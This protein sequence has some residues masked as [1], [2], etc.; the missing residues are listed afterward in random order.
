MRARGRR[1]RP[2]SLVDCD[3]CGRDFVVPV[4]WLDLDEERWWIRTRCGEC[5]TAREVVVGNE[6]ARRFEADLD[7]GARKLARSLRR[8]ERVRRDPDQR[9]L[10]PAPDDRPRPPAGRSLRQR[11]RGTT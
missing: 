8:A 11:K 7:I 5:G 3:H 9:N 1:D 4:S 10:Q 6:E 2:S